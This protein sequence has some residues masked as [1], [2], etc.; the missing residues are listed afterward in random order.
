MKK[1][2]DEKISWTESIIKDYFGDNDIVQRVL[3]VFAEEGIPSHIN[4]NA[5]EFLEI[6]KWI[7]KVKGAD[8]HC[9]YRLLA[10]DENKIDCA[11]ISGRPCISR[12]SKTCPI[13]KNKGERFLF[14]L[15]RIGEILNAEGL[16]PKDDPFVKLI[17]QALDKTLS[18][19]FCPREIA[20]ALFALYDFLVEFVI[21]R[22]VEI[23][24]GH[25][26]RETK[27]EEKI[28]LARSLRK[29]GKI[30][31][32]LQ[33]LKKIE[34]IDK[35]YCKDYD[36]VEGRIVELEIKLGERP[37]LKSLKRTIKHNGRKIILKYAKEQG[38][39]LM[40]K[41]DYTGAIEYFKVIPKKYLDSE[42]LKIYAA[43]YEK[44][45]DIKSAYK[46]Y[47]QVSA[48]ESHLNLARCNFKLQ[49]YEECWKEITLLF[50][51]G[52]IPVK[53]LEAALKM[54][55]DLDNAMQLSQGDKDDI[56]SLCNVVLSKKP[57]SK[58]ARGIF[59]K[60]E[61]EKKERINSRKKASEG[62]IKKRKF[63][64]ARNVLLKIPKNRQD[65]WIIKKVAFCYKKEGAY[66]NSLIWYKK[67]PNPKSKDVLW[68]MILFALRVKDFNF[69]S[70][71]CRELKKVN[72]DM[73]EIPHSDVKAFILES[74]GNYED[75]INCCVNKD[76]ILRFADK[77]KKDKK[78]LLCAECFLNIHKKLAT[79]GYKK[80]AED[81]LEKYGNS[82]PINET[83][84]VRRSLEKKYQVSLSRKELVICDTNV[85]VHKGFYGTRGYERLDK[86]LKRRVELIV[87]KFNSL[88]NT[89][90][91]GATNTAREQLRPVCKRLFR[92][93]NVE[94]EKEREI[95]MERAKKY[96]QKYKQDVVLDEGALDKVRKFYLPFVFHTKKITEW[97]IKNKSENESTKIIGKRD[98][99]LMPEESDMKLLA[100][101]ISLYNSHVKG[102]NQ[103][104]LL[105]DDL[106]FKEFR[107][108]IKSR[109]DIKVY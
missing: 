56:L 20:L 80:K 55:E 98:G 73:N 12:S 105:S 79:K 70:E 99:G 58:V 27:V 85:F 47:K 64:R 7:N 65:D 33:I 78:F 44:T 57:E 84:E 11:I 106:D 39:S 53:T 89:Q 96:I 50:S 87:N 24:Q 92:I 16:N 94:D 32:E 31:E 60:I 104:S 17:I 107:D 86:N 34:K 72:I 71:L 30:K 45:G 88:S 1:E 19:G 67:L 83:V 35:E 77:L 26:K 102:I 15:T 103:I 109:F 28:K 10:I 42:S 100:E 8:K 101:C 76:L 68:D 25:K 38:I 97:K 14:S 95:V 62:F 4:E 40:Q 6:L 91:I 36:A 75:A 3:E 41:N 61:R 13:Y 5:E 2:K 93:L 21:D 29:K 22:T 63:R 54:I 37:S 9:E 69:A 82:L 49:K 90:R 74:E 108:E 81:V 46:L 59:E 51:L 23:M 18:N 52:N 48:P 43:C 66:K